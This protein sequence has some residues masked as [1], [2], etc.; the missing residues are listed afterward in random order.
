MQH[1]LATAM[2]ATCA[3]IGGALLDLSKALAI[4][5]DTPVEPTPCPLPHVVEQPAPPEPV[6]K[7]WTP[8]E[9]AQALRVHERTVY[10]WIRQGVLAAIPKGKRGYVIPEVEVQRLLQEAVDKAAKKRA[11]QERSACSSSTSGVMSP[12]A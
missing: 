9:V 1:D 12:R 8:K 2:A 7:V 5:A 3:A 10:R 6:V 11:E 4:A